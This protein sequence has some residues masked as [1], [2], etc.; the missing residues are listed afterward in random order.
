MCSLHLGSRL[1]RLSVSCIR[2]FSRGRDAWPTAAGNGPA[3]ASGR[4]ARSREPNPAPRSIE[5][6]ASWSE[7]GR[8]AS[9]LPGEALIF[10]VHEVFPVDALEPADDEVAA[11]DVLEMLDERVIHRG[12]PHRADHRDGLAAGF[13]RH[14]H[15]E[16][17]RDLRDEANEDRAAFLDHTALGDEARGLRDALG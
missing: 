3:G 5:A 11:G 1:I 17:R 6:V 15:A 12:A 9:I 4:W 8:P 16:A 2:I 13:L 7:I 10:P 14:H